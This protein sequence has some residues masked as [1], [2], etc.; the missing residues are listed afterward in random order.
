MGNE[1]AI[2]SASLHLKFEFEFVK[3]KHDSC[4]QQAL[5]NLSPVSILSFLMALETI[6]PSSVYSS[7]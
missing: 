7:I 4:T 3:N 2:I 1:I 6:L 5:K